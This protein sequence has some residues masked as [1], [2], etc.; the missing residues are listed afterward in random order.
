MRLLFKGGFYS[1]KYG[2]RFS[3]DIIFS[4]LVSFACILVFLLVCLFFEIKNIYSD[5]HSTMREVSGKN[6]FTRLISGNKTT[7]FG[8]SQWFVLWI[9]L[10]LVNRFDSLFCMNVSIWLYMILSKTF[11]R[12]NKTRTG[13]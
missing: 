8:L 6:F 7:F 12:L 10:K 5:T 3:G 11:E 1:R 4:S 2:S 13:L 9:L